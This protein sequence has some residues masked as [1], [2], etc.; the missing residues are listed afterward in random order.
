VVH[1]LFEHSLLI[2]VIL[3]FILATISYKKGHVSARCWKAAVMLFPLQIILCAWFR[4]IFVVLAYENVRG[5]TA[6]FLGLQIALLIVAILNTA[7]IIETKSSHSFLGGLQGTRITAFTCLTGNLIVSSIKACFSAFVVFGLGGDN[8]YPQWALQK[9][10]G[11][12]KGIGQVVD[13]VWMI[14]NALLPMI[15]AAVRARSEPPLEFTIDLGKPENSVSV[16]NRPSSEAV[17][18]PVGDAVAS[19]QAEI[20]ELDTM[21]FDK[22]PL[23]DESVDI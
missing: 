15:I 8:I 18:Q 14:F 20:S 3:D 21:G 23:L 13:V 19:S 6:G 22:T 1:P 4:V 11:S 5:H 12:E 2:Y 9:V 17:E 7:Y 16:S 10:A